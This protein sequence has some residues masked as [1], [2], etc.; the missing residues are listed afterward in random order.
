MRSSGRAAATVALAFGALA[1]VLGFPP[2]EAAAAPPSFRWNRPA[3]LHERGPQSLPVDLPLL[4]GSAPFR[5]EAWPGP[6]GTPVRRLA[7]GGLADLRFYDLLGREVPYLL[8][9]PSFAEPAWRRAATILPVPATKKTSGFEADLGAASTVDRLRLEGLPAPFLKRLALDGSG[10]R[11]HWTRLAPEATLFDLP[12]SN[13]RQIELSFPAGLFRYLR[14]SWDDASSAR[15]PLPG[16][17]LAR[18]VRADA[19][20]R[21]ALSAPL[22]FARRASEPGASRFR[23]RLPAVALPAVALRLHVGGGNLLRRARVTEARLAGEC[24]A[25]FALG[26]AT[27]RR[28]VRDVLAADELRVPLEAPA[29][30]ELELEVDDADNP[31]LDLQAVELELAELPWIYLEVAEPSSLVARWGQP[32]LVAPRYDLESARE[33]AAR[34]PAPPA[35]SWG[36]MPAASLQGPS[37]TPAALPPAGPAL[38]TTGFR[39]TRTLSAGPPGLVAV[40]LDAAVLAHSSGG[41]AGDFCDLRMVDAASRQVP[42]LLDRRSEPLVIPLPPFALAGER[43]ARFGADT[44][45]YRLRLPYP[46]LPPSRL[47]LRTSARVFDREVRVLVEPGPGERRKKG[48]AQTVASATW[49]G[50]DPDTAAAA[51]TLALPTLATADVLLA[52]SE[53]DNPPLPLD[54]P[55]LLLPSWHVRLFRAPGEIRVL[56]GKDRLAPPRYDLALLGRSVL[57][58]PALESALSAEGEATPAESVILRPAAFWT[59]MVAAVAVLLGLIARLVRRQPGSPE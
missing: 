28:T 2:R 37:D 52:V 19:A 25:P 18:I 6:P 1:A 33:R 3:V 43:V 35:G 13:L 17:A 47:V 5:V 16:S 34:S 57:A 48:G 44:T 27:L 20:A 21:S 23:L 11:R 55:E 39:Y 24:T 49:R 12:D 51:L 10:D 7:R 32:G 54:S 58:S 30:A 50:A 4:V 26:E 9:E 53:G 40:P 31:P 36:E 22:A 38:D 45:V 8:V 46:A 14:V 29:T 42:Y 59:L 56:Y 15:V 41:L